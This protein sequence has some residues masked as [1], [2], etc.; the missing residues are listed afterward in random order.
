MAELILG[1]IL[2][3]VDAT[4]ATVWVETDG[5]CEVEMLGRARTDVPRR[6]AITTRW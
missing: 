5:P 2:R 4:S 6:R 3:Y 1:P